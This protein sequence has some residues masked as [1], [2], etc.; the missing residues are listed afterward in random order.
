MD[1][2]ELGKL[3]FRQAA[4][5][6]AQYLTIHTNIRPDPDILTAAL[7]KHV[8]AAIPQAL[9]DGK[10]A[11]DCRMDQI[12]CDTFLASFTIA[13]INAAKEVCGV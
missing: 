10:A 6:A 7:K 3:V 4:R 9:A 1:D 13:G 12:A 11:L 5:A 2:N 8:K